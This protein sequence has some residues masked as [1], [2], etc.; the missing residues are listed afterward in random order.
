MSE[1]PSSFNKILSVKIA[2]YLQIVF[3]HVFIILLNQLNS[4]VQHQAAIYFHQAPR[5]VQS[6]VTI[7]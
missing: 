7:A 2:F 5:F 1:K 4:S 3:V 6:Y